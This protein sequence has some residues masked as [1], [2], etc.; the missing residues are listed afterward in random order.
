MKQESLQWNCALNQVD[1]PFCL[2]NAD[3]QTAAETF[4]SVIDE[5]LT[6]VQ[7][8]AHTDTHTVPRP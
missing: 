2:L 5:Q 6:Q 7:T 3:K 8:H 1:S 4:Y